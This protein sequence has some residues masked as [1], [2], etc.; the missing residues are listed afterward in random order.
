MLRIDG[1]SA[2]Y[3]R[4]TAL[5]DV[6]LEVDEGEI[7]ALLGAN[8]AGKTT[9]LR[10]LSGVHPAR[11]G[12]ILLDGKPIE[13]SKPH[14]RVDLGIA[15][16][17]EGRQVFKSLSVEDNLRLGAY[18]RRDRDI[19]RDTDEVYAL[20]PVLGEMRK[21]IASAL[22]GGQQQMLAIGRA[23]LSRP[24][25]LLL[26]EP[27]LGL[28]PLIIDQIFGIVASLK[29]KGITVLVVEQNIAVALG[30][31]D[32]GYV[33]ETGRIVHTGTA[34]ALLDDPAVRDAYL[35]V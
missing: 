22:S 12:R 18:R 4:V 26:D 28:A 20:F 25:L 24:R 33:L 6:S 1:L 30:I 27:S 9:L 16:S 14:T 3:G 21:R 23:L 29:E 34:R 35:G 7:V 13:R 10:T 32:R 11:R 19:A 8:G 31:A 5:Q 15:Q 2:A 17:P